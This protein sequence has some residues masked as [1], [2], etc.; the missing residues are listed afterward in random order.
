M[1]NIYWWLFVFSLIK[2]YKLFVTC[3]LGDAI[4][5]SSLRSSPL[6][7]NVQMK[8]I[9]IC[10][11]LIFVQQSVMVSHIVVIMSLFLSFS[12]V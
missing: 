1:I 3:V 10:N 2:L 6:T 9:I 4:V 12:A 5:Y 11:T 8:K 7:K